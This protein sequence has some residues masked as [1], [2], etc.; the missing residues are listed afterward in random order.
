MWA[1]LAAA[2]VVTA[3]AEYELARACG[4]GQLV[5][6]AVPAALD[7]YAV[8]A[9]RARKDVAA[10]VIAMIVV[11]ALS[12]LVTAQ[13]IP[14]NVPL[15]VAVSAIAPLVLWR[16]HALR[17]C[18]PDA[19][20]TSQPVPESR[21]VPAAV[22]ETVPAGVRLL[23]IVARPEPQRNEIRNESPGAVLAAE[24]PRTSVSEPVPDDDG[25]L[26]ERV[27]GD[28][29]NQIPTYRELKETYSIGQG[30]AKRIRGV[31]ESRAPN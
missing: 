31:L 25:E 27:R 26:V 10:T 15:V 9:L 13:L 4:F 11:N 8:R 3:S 19:P 18:E 6:G 12:H 23:P 7:I 30:R 2:L 1:A 28:F 24:S 17:G 29:N 16:V 14:V 22:P 20:E 5:A 21:P